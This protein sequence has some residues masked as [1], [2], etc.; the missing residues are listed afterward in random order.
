[1]KKIVFLITSFVL[2]SACKPQTPP[3]APESQTQDQAI[4]EFTEMGQAIQSGKPVS[5]TMQKKDSTESVT[6]LI[7]GKKMKMSGFGSG[8]AGQPGS[9]LSDGEYVYTWTDATKQGMKFKLPSEEAQQTT[10]EQTPTTP[11]NVPDFSSEEERQKYADMGYTVN[12]EVAVVA[13]S[14]FVPPTDVTFR[15]LSSMMQAL[16]SATAPVMD[17]AEAQRRA[18]EMMQQYAQ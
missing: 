6:Y 1:M 18:Q 11:Q 4:N 13:D 5:C 14:E 17:Q 3:A 10:T 7:K 16:P 9:M 8:D 15:D 2:F 12:C